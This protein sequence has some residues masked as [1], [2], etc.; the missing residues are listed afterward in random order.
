MSGCTFNTQQPVLPCNSNACPAVPLPIVEQPWQSGSARYQTLS[1][2]ARIV[3]IR[4]LIDP[5]LSEPYSI[6]TYRYFL[7]SWPDLCYLALDGGRCC[8]AVVAKLERHRDALMRGYIAMLVVDEQTRGHGI[9]ALLDDAGGGWRGGVYKSG[10]TLH[11]YICI[12]LV[13]AARPSARLPD[14]SR[15]RGRICAH[16][17]SCP[18][19]IVHRKPAGA[20]RDQEPGGVW[21]RGGGSGGRGDQC[22]RAAAL[23]ASRISP[24]QAAEEVGGHTGWGTIVVRGFFIVCATASRHLCS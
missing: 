14:V 11:D 23:R 19:K 20:A 5:G 13:Q 18:P 6:F 4:D 7:S 8:G 21:L 1:I 10:H 2:S 16:P 24:G 22:G 17:L 15:I 12:G 9:G 3:Q